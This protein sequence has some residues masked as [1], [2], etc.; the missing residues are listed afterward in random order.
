MNTKDPIRLG[1]PRGGPIQL[2]H[3]FIRNFIALGS[4]RAQLKAEIVN[5]VATPSAFLTTEMRAAPARAINRPPFTPRSELAPS[6]MGKGP[7]HQVSD[8]CSGAAAYFGWK[9]WA[10]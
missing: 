2:A 9:R 10:P 6:S 8:W 4:D 3:E 5:I 1:V 7:V